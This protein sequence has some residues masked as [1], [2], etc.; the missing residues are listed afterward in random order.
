MVGYADSGGDAAALAELTRRLTDWRP[1]QVGTLMFLRRGPEVLLIEKL[2]G[3]GA[4]RING[5]GGKPEPAET[6]VDCAIRET[7]EEVGVRPL[8]PRLAG[9]FRFVDEEDADWLGYVY[10]A[11]SFV[12]TPTATAEAVPEW[13][14]ADALPF[15]RMWDDDRHWLPRVLAGERVEGNFLFRRGV[16]VAYRLRA[17]GKD[18]PFSFG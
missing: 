13:H 4:G 15:E 6:P 18:E 10:L 14:R 9:V 7:V 3:H 17:L 16:L 1:D 2:R 5:P 12:G 11:R 8:D